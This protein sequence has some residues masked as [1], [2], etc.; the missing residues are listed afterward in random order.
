MLT[1][2][3][4]LTESWISCNYAAAVLRSSFENCEKSENVQTLTTPLKLVVSLNYKSRLIRA[5]FFSHTSAISAICFLKSFEIS[6]Y[7]VL[8]LILTPACENKS[9]VDAEV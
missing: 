7:P 1:I 6:K 3:G 9:A 4:T 8:I 2:E 5:V